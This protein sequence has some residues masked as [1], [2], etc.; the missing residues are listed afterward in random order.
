MA[1]RELMPG[2]RNV[3]RLIRSVGPR[4]EE[5]FFLGEEIDTFAS[6]VAGQDQD[7]E[8][9]FEI[10]CLEKREGSGFEALT[11]ELTM[12]YRLVGEAQPIYTVTARVSPN[13]LYSSLDVLHDSPSAVELFEFG[14]TVTA[15]IELYWPERI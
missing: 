9:V 5:A 15:E 1:E 3:V 10:L 11:H 4:F 12:N 14:N 8:Y 7:H 13:G 6:F 2:L